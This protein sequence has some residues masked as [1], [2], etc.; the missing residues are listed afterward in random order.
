MMVS[1]TVMNALIFKKQMGDRGCKPVTSSCKAIS[2]HATF[3]IKAPLCNIVYFRIP[4]SPKLKC[5]NV[6]TKD[7]G[8]LVFTVQK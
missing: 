4:N 7:P 2:G 8:L 6:K 3:I 5:E 1:T